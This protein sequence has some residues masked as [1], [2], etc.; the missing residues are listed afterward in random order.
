M[1]YPTQLISVVGSAMSTSSAKCDAGGISPVDTLP[2]EIL[3]LIFEEAFKPRPKRFGC[4][5]ELRI[6]RVSQ[7]WRNVAIRTPFLW[8][9]IYLS[10]YTW[11]DQL[12][13]YLF[14]SGLRP[15]DVMVEIRPN[16]VTGRPERA[17]VDDLCN[18]IAK[19]V[20]RCQFM[21]LFI[22]R[23]D[24]MYEALTSLTSA[25]ALQLVH[26]RLY[27]SA[28]S[29]N[30]DFPTPDILRGGAP[31]LRSIVFVATPC[32]FTPQLDS[33]TNVELHDI[34]DV[35]LSQEAVEMLPRFSALSHLVLRDLYA[36]ED[37][38]DDPPLSKVELPSLRTLHLIKVSYIDDPTVICLPMLIIEAPKLECL[39]LDGVSED[40]WSDI[41]DEPSSL[42]YTTSL[43]YLV[44]DGYTDDICL[45]QRICAACP[46]ILDFTL[47]D[48]PPACVLGA[49]SMPSDGAN[50]IFWPDLRILTIDVCD[51]EDIANICDMLTSRNQVGHPVPTILLNRGSLDASD[52]K[53]GR[54]SGLANISNLK[55]GKVLKLGSP[56]WWDSL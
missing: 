12:E 17:S 46:G 33:V 52:D 44:V 6:S 23:S 32:F 14:R 50:R 37:P 28:F 39:F 40:D 30:E 9:R 41:L 54:L 21:H 35:R 11:A 16:S 56:D 25:A 10:L 42:V 1:H 2:N 13:C 38:E 43:R 15:L 47:L 27:T 24:H 7:R 31:V 4:S 22:E 55:R 3:V 18:A 49:L 19:V 20:H 45:W 29:N 5:T 48:L 8:T 36:N 34:P 26:L 51:E 53:M